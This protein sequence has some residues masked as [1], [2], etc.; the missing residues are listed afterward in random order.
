LA[1]D[2]LVEEARWEK[3]D[4]LLAM[5]VPSSQRAGAAGSWRDGL[6]AGRCCTLF[7]ARL[8]ALDSHTRSP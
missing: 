2:R 5:L 8:L 1:E 4:A 3:P 7:A 6:V